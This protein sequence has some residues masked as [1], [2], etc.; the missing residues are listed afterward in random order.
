[1]VNP[2]QTPQNNQPSQAVRSVNVQ[3]A[4][5]QKI[6][7]LVLMVATLGLGT[8]LALKNDNGVGTAAVFAMSLILLIIGFGGVLPT[9][10]KVGDVEVAMQQAQQEGANAVAKV[11]LAND[12]KAAAQ[13]VA[14][15]YPQLANQAAI[16]A[17]AAIVHPDAFQNAKGNEQLKEAIADVKPAQI[18]AVVEKIDDVA[19]QVDAKL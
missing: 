7:A 4:P 12:P 6:T 1:M 15:E 10:L 3:L 5:W 13:A 8:Y 18:D 19:K 17:T 9:S 16:A 14:N 11:A 2:S